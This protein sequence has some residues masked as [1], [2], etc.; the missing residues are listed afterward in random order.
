MTSTHRAPRLPR[1]SLLGLVGLGAAALAGCAPSPLITPGAGS[2]PL[3]PPTLTDA[4]RSAAR[5][6]ATLAEAAVAAGQAPGV[7]GSFATWCTA[8]A[9]LHRAHLEVL[10]QADPLGGVQADHSPI[11]EI[12]AARFEAPT[13]QASAM[14][15]LA[16]LE[17]GLAEELAGVGAQAGHSP[18]EALLWISQQVAAAIHGG[19][20]SAGDLAALGPAPVAGGAVPAELTE[21]GSP[22]D[23]RQVLLSHQR[24]LVFGLQAVLGR[25]AFDDPMVDVVSA[26]LG[27]VMRDRDATAAAL[28]AADATPEPP[29]AQYQLPGDAT[30]PAQRDQIWG[31]LELA[32]ATGW[33]RLAAVDAADRMTAVNSMTDQCNRAR[34]LGIALPHWPGWV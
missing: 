14:A 5:A 7:D 25:L 26:R 9:Q 33:A 24:A 21:P 19:A 16:G 17:T 23:A 6:A 18:G 8:L 1:R 28:V 15:L 32:V 4:R 12:T 20:L 11:E 10:A 2:T 31:R 30:D 29:A 22:D 3:P 34:R 27:E 13:D